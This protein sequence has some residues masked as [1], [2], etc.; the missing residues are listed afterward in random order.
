MAKISNASLHAMDAIMSSGQRGVMLPNTPGAFYGPGM[1]TGGV[2]SGMVFLV[3]ELEKQDP[4]LLEP[5]KS[6]TA[7]RDIMMKSGG[8]WV[9]HTS[10]VFVAYGT[11]SNDEDSIV[12]GETTNIPVSQATITKDIFK[13]VTFAEILSAPIFD[14]M[15][16][17]QV[18]RSLTQIL[19]DGIRLN[20]AKILDRNVYTGITKTGTTGLVNNTS[21]TAG[22]VATGASGYTT[23]AT[24]TPTE[25]LAD[26]NLIIEQTW[27]ASEYDLTGM[28]NQ[29]LIDPVNYAY[30]ASKPVTIAATET[31]LDFLYKHN[32]AV[33]QGRKVE[34][35][36]CRQ[37]LAAGSGQTQ[38]MVCYV[39][40]ENRVCMDNTVPLSRVMTAPNVHNAAYETLFA[41]QFG[42]VKW[43]YLQCV[44]YADG[45]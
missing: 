11:T 23:W 35:F 2:A 40:E 12:A 32:I 4:R 43:L 29:I 24:K 13:V 41:A 3:G 9:S 39:N 18:G 44:R 17:K 45:I 7:P 27:A 22:S 28:G 26:I 33:R 16:L 25:I 42:Q 21:I 34:I 15:K 6:I 30:I 31:I 10:N 36:P 14:E 8:G 38:R 20:Y 5:L 19:D 37:C 1:D